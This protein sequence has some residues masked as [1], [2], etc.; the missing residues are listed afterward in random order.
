[1]GVGAGRR[2][3]VLGSPIAHSRS[4][5]LHR[6]AYVHLGLDWTY[7]GPADVFAEMKHAMP[8]LDNITW[9]RLERENAVTYPCDGPDV[10]GN[11]IV[12][13]DRF[14]TPTGLG[15]FVPA[16]VVPPD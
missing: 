7:E 1:M 3:A 16:E 2:C 15:K 13:G 11:D 10:P 14:P 8:S 9:E 4:P 6:A 5:R 12:F